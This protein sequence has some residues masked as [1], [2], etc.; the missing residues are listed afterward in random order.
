MDS[1]LSYLIYHY[2]YYYYYY[3]YSHHHY[4]SFLTLQKILTF[5]TFLACFHTSGLSFSLSLS[6]SPFLLSHFIIILL[7]VYYATL[8]LY[9]I[10]IFYFC[11]FLCLFDQSLSV[12][13]ETVFYRNKTELVLM[14]IKYIVHVFLGFLPFFLEIT[15]GLYQ[16]LPLSLSLKIIRYSSL[17]KEGK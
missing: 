8:L 16:L 9:S 2:Y 17:L 12:R 7:L 14:M 15:L 11:L 5:P 4:F 6:I 1:F 10:N 13:F 3:Y